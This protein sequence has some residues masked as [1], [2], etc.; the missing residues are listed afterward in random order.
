MLIF[1]TLNYKK[2][3]VPIITSGL[4]TVFECYLLQS[5]SRILLT[6]EKEIVVPVI[7]IYKHYEFV[8]DVNVEKKVR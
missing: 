8:L 3:K 1:N 5:P 4:Y 2:Q 7:N 6:E